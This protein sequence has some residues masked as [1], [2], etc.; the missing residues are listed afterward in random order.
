MFNKNESNNEDLKN[1]GIF[2][3]IIEAFRNFFNKFKKDKNT[4]IEDNANKNINDIVDIDINVTGENKINNDEYLNLDSNNYFE[5]RYNNYLKK[6][7]RCKNTKNYDKK[8][9]EFFRNGKIKIKDIEYPINSFYIVYRNINSLKE[10][11]LISTKVGC[12]DFISNEKINVKDYKIIK[13]CDTTAFVSFYNIF[14]IDDSVLIIED[15]EL[16][17]KIIYDW[18]GN[19]HTLTPY[20][21]AIINK[22]VI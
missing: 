5:Y 3:F 8:I 14:Q 10:I 9:C 12:I 2:S 21:D 22:H 16:L 4:N 19:I 20:C 15:F 7:V 13:F 1:K 17:K 11:G 18:D 6:V